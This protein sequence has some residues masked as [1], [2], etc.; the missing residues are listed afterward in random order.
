MFRFLLP[1]DQDTAKTVHPAM[2]A[3]DD[4]TPCT[5]ASLLSQF[6]RFTNEQL[7]LRRKM[8]EPAVCRLFK[9]GLIY[10]S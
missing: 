6:A 8:K 7:E 2:G 1:T 5:L 3:F 9:V 10:S 4:P